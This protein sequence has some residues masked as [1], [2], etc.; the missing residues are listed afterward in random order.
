VRLQ[1]ETGGRNIQK[2]NDLWRDAKERY[3]ISFSSIS[4]RFIKC[5]D[6]VAIREMNCFEMS[7]TSWPFL[8][9]LEE[10]APE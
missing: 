4:A 10:S 8:L 9:V 3:C 1:G 7:V 5:H 6:T 2:G